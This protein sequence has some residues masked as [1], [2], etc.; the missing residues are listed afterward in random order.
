MPIYEYKCPKCELKF[1]HMRPFSRA[2]EDASCPRCHECSPR[3]PSRFAAFSTGEGGVA[4]PVGGSS[5][6]GCSSTN[7]GTCA[8]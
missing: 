2:E 3:A 6:A 1:E 8:A 5:C 7:C 4:S